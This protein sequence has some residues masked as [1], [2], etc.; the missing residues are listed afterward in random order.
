[1]IE[2]LEYEQLFS[3]TLGTWLFIVYRSNRL[4][5]SREITTKVNKQK[6]LNVLFFSF[7]LR[8]LSPMRPT[9]LRLSPIQLLLADS[10]L[11]KVQDLPIEATT[12][13]QTKRIL[14]CHHR[15]NGW[16]RKCERVQNSLPG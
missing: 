1:M 15:P 7:H 12:K 9:L 4:N 13:H 5:A 11:L 16:I 2:F 6:S 10:F 3:H 14:H 8:F